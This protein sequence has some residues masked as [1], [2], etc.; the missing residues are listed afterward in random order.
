MPIFLII[1]SSD[2][3]FYVSRFVEQSFRPRHIRKLVAVL[4][5]L[6]DS[7]SIVVFFYNSL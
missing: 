7:N 1:Q 3:S 4:P 6:L 5:K 2:S